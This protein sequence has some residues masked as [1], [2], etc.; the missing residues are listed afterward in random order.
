M[1][2]KR[3]KVRTTGTRNSGAEASDFFARP[4]VPE[5]TWEAQM[6]GAP[7]DA[8]APYSLSARYAKGALVLHSKFGKGV[9]VEADAQRVEVLF[10]D[11]KRKLGHA[12]S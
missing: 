1:S 10:S 7:E 12:A 9:I 3:A 8:F 11:G 6:E 5:K 2:M 4:A